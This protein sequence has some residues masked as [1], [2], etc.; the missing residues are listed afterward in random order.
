MTR[1]DLLRQELGS[2]DPRRR[3]QAIFAVVKEDNKELSGCVLSIFR[4]EASGSI[5]GLCAWALGKLQCKDAY[6]DLVKA[7]EEGSPEVR[8]WSAWA[9][10]EIGLCEGANPLGRALEAERNPSVRRAIGGA[11]KK[12]RF[13]PTRDHVGAVMRRLR[14]PPTS[15][16]RTRFIVQNLASLEWPLEKEAIVELRKQLQESDPAYFRAYMEWLRR[17]P[18]IE[19][20]LLDPKKV[21]SDF[22]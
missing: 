6:A 4:R 16:E 1:V 5:K 18:S 10:G 19:R 17:K 8:S 22:E 2:L 21:Y 13:E 14:P 7:L 15:D 3:R 12:L 9:L 11:L 20:A